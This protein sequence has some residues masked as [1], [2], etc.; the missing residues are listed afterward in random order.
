MDHR[1]K[2]QAARPVFSSDNKKTSQKRHLLF[3]FS[4]NSYR[5]VVKSVDWCGF[6]GKTMFLG[7]YLNKLDSKG[8]IAI[9]AKFRGDLGNTVV[10]N[11]YLDGCLA[12][13]TQEDWNA[14]YASL[15][16]LPSNK[17]EVRKYQRSMTSAASEQSFDSQG[18]IL[19]PSELIRLAGL[20]KDCVF[21]GAGNHVELWSLDK[22]NEYNA[23]LTEE[24]IEKISENL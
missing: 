13:Y 15:M 9:P 21:I 6:V 19:I 8:R 18:R 5:L 3:T 7:K 16:A 4:G 17:A 22:W 11:R 1:E 14:I 10:V 20:D 12:I 2:Q 24:E 23:S